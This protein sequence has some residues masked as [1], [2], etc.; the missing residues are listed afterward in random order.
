MY[1][2]DT[3]VISELRRSKPHG[4]VKAWLASVPDANL[5][6]SAVSLAEIQRGVENARETDPAKAGEIESWADKIELTFSVLPVDAPVFR[7][8]ARWMHRRSDACY[9]DALIAATAKIHGLVVVTR[10]VI[11]FTEFDIGL[12]D[13]FGFRSASE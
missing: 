12:F 4:A 11:D 5:Q 1:L 7:L 10:N 3:N 6:I 13:P 2:L 8:H 9:E